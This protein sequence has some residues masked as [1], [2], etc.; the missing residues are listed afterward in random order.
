MCPVCMTTA[1]VIATGTGA[2]ACLTTLVLGKLRP[3]RHAEAS[4]P[5]PQSDSTPQQEEK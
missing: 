3:E 4:N 5:N 2:A 1:A